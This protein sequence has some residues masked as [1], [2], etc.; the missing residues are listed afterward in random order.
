M[1]YFELV[2]WAARCEFNN[3]RAEES[4]R[5]FSW[6]GKRRGTKSFF[7]AGVDETDHM[8]GQLFQDDLTHRVVSLRVCCAKLTFLGEVS[9]TIDK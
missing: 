4:R 1:V 2:A 9:R 6:G 7:E 8:G 5:R 3:G